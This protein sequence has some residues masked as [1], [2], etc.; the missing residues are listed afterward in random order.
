MRFHQMVLLTLSCSC[1][2]ELSIAC[3]V[4]PKEQSDPCREKQCGWGSQC[5]VSSDG[6]NASCTCPDKCPGYGDHDA[7][8]PVC[9]SDAVDYA[10]L[11]ELR[12]AACTQNTN[13]TVKFAGKC[14][15]CAGV[16]CAEP[17]VC[18]LD[19][20]RNPVCRCGDTCPLEFTPVCGSD[21]KTYSNECTLRQEACRARKTLN[22]IYRGKCSSGINPCMSVRCTMGEECAINKF[23]IAHCQCPSSCEPVMRPVCSK[24]GRTFPSEC[25]LR[26]AAC[27]GRSNIEI[28]YAGVCGEKGPCTDH[29]CQFGAT[30]VER[31]GTAHCECPH[32]SAEFQP[33]CGSD[34]ISYGNECKLKLEACK[35]R[36]EINVLYEGPCNGC[37][38]KKCDFY[39]VCESDGAT[40]G[41]C[42]CPQTCS[43]VK[44]TNGTVCGTDG[45]TYG[46]EC[47]LRLNSC[48]TKQYVLLAYKG[49]CD[50]CQGVECKYGSRCEAGECVCPQTAQALEMNLYVLPT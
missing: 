9:G 18:Q 34:G 37:E 38:N 50:M 13:I 26:R 19:E 5:V 36:R 48:K 27:S 15:P 43:D 6:R 41:R 31:S 32:C 8:R 28:A 7:S 10:D 20:Q 44:L 12:R 2:L 14:D 1:I 21:G 11:C 39:S 45:V 24:D 3:Y 22:I 30:C 4:F 33:V 23:G 25:E 35:H 49:N 16:Q 40:E 47:E 42:V 46:N 17:E 29:N